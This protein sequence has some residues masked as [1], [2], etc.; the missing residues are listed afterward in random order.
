MSLPTQEQ[1]EDEE[2]VLAERV[3]KL[4]SA[5]AHFLSEWKQ[6]EEENDK[7]HKQISQLVDSQKIQDI[8]SSIAQL[9]S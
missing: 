6:I 3:R 4:Q 7:V 1:L 9:P 8:A 5:Y 2:R